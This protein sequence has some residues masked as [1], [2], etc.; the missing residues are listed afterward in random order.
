[1]V[2]ASQFAARS[3]AS[4]VETIARIVEME[5]LDSEVRTALEEIDSGKATAEDHHDKLQ[6]WLNARN[7]KHDRATNAAAWFI[8]DAHGKQLVRSPF[9]SETEGQTFSGRDYFHGRGLEIPAKDIDANPPA[10]IQASH[11]SRPYRSKASGELMIA[12]S[13]PIWSGRPRAAGSRV[14]GVLAA[15]VSA[16]RFDVLQLGAS[17]DEQQEIVV[18]VDLREDWLEQTMPRRGLILHHQNLGRV[19]P[20]PSRRNDPVRVG[21]ETVGRLLELHDGG[22]LQGWIQRRYLDPVGGDW[23]AAFAPVLVQEGN[24]DAETTDE[25]NDLLWGVIVQRRLP[26]PAR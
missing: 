21:A 20:D 15:T 12:F 24:R 11:V 8:T 16:N 5:A 19:R 18:L 4:V 17:G 6:S 1:L 14:L 25:S 26:E 23:M 3:V 9:S 7:L 2:L 10:P 13:T 22:G